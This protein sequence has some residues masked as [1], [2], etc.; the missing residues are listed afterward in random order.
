MNHQLKDHLSNNVP[1]MQC[2]TDFIYLLSF[3]TAM[4]RVDFPLHVTK[5]SDVTEQRD[6]VQKSHK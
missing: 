3:P 6:K 5:E 2:S 1:Q 4:T